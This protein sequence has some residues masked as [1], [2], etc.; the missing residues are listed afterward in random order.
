MKNKVEKVI[1]RRKEENGRKVK[2]SYG[3]DRLDGILCCQR[4]C[5]RDS[6]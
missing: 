1:H 4:K 3:E 2:R 6:E 5:V